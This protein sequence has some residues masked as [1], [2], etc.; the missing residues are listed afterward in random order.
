LP[1]VT[2]YQFHANESDVESIWE[3]ACNELDQLS[4]K[5]TFKKF[6]CITFDQITFWASLLPDNGDALMKMHSAIAGIVNQPIKANFD[7]H[8]TLISTKDPSY[9][10]FVNELAKKYVPIQDVFTLALGKSDNIGQL[11]EVIYSCKLKNNL[12]LDQ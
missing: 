1:H 6:S 8:M 11:T 2:L 4:I 10:H 9:E 3:M 12:S 5:L 7:P